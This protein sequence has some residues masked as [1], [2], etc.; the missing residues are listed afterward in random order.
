MA[1][2]ALSGT[3][4][5]DECRTTALNLVSGGVP[6]AEPDVDRLGILILKRWTP[7]P[8]AEPGTLRCVTK[9]LRKQLLVT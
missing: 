7:G 9:G 5:T 8:Q 4:S 3:H 2:A 6:A 1:L